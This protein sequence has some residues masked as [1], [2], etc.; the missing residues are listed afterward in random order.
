NL[1]GEI[2]PGTDQL[3]L[4]DRASFQPDEWIRRGSNAPDRG[5]DLFAG[6][7]QR[8]EMTIAFN[9]T[10]VF[11]LTIRNYGNAS[12]QF[13]FRAPTNVTGGIKARYFLQPA[14]TEISGTATNAGWVSDIV[15]PGDSRE[16]RVQITANNTN[17]FNQDLVFT[18]ASFS[19]PSKVDVVRLRLLR[20][21]DN[22]GLPN[23]WEQQYFL[24]PTNA[25]ASADTDGDGF[26]NYQE[27]I[28]GTNPTNRN[29][30]LRI[31]NVQPG[32]GPA[33]TITWPSATNR[34]YT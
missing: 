31:T 3:L 10:N 22:D 8:V 21:D 33:V 27:Y 24:N 13:I 11:F 34:F 26:S 5:Q 28:A 20:D 12:D 17:L 7:G 1:L 9:A 15:T 30:T 19:D 4:Y 16:V 14:G 6:S 29:S 23:T 2:N 25:V 18:S 32:A